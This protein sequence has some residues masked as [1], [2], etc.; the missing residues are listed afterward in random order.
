MVILTIFIFLAIPLIFQFSIGNK[1]INKFVKIP[2][3]L[4]CLISVLILIIV[5]II[6][7]I[8]GKMLEISLFSLYT[9]VILFVIVIIQLFVHFSNK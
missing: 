9:G 5:T 6:N 2:Y 1:A 8:I 7:V 4:V 3:A